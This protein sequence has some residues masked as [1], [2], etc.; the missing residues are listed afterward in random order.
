MTTVR[1]LVSLTAVLWSQS[2]LGSATLFLLGHPWALSWSFRVG[3]RGR[4]VGLG[5]LRRPE[6]S[7]VLG[8]ARQ[9]WAAGPG[10]ESLWG[11]PLASQLAGREEL[12]SQPQGFAPHL[13][14]HCSC[15]QTPHYI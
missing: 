1:T 10:P 9:A 3:R 6:D 2:M 7:H 12:R 5:L 15:V 4:W 13:Q 14:P 11:T 8:N